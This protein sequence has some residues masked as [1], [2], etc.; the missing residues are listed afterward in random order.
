M[1]TAN[2]SAKKQQINLLDIIIPHGQLC[3][4]QIGVTK[5][6][7]SPQ[8]TS[9]HTERFCLVLLCSQPDTVRRFLSRKT[10]ISTSLFEGSPTRNDPRPTN[11]P[12]IADCR[13]RAP[14]TPRLCGITSISK[15][16]MLVKQCF[17]SRF[18]LFYPEAG[19]EILQHL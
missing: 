8:A 4:V 7:N 5:I 3:R 10:Q 17:I 14:L 11:T 12:A 9:R 15:S 1:N 6:V 16:K 18:I 2:I 19:K 13:Y